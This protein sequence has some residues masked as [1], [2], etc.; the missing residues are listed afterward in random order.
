MYIYIYNIYY[1]YICTI[2]LYVLFERLPAERSNLY[3]QNKIV[4]L[5]YIFGKKTTTTT[6]TT[7]TTKLCL[8]L[9]LGIHFFD[10]FEFQK[11]EKKRVYIFFDVKNKL[12]HIYIYI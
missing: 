10:F 6:T 2:D 9:F 4:R 5:N 7:T 12:I 1:V 8:A 11:N 3:I